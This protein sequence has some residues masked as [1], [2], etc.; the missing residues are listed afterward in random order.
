MDTQ[1]KTAIEAA[2]SSGGTLPASSR[3]MLDVPIDIGGTMVTE[4]TVLKPKAGA[5]MG[6]SLNSLFSGDVET[7]I[8]VIPNCTMP[9]IS[10]LHIK[11]GLL[12]LADMSAIHSEIVSFFLTK[13]QR[14]RLPPSG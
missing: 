14:E 11:E 13:A 12:D 1:T 7:L 2:S 8:R 6:V 3:V 4:V 9:M 10:K 5:L